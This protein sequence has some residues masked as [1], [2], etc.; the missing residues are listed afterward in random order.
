MFL[1]QEIEGL[2]GKQ[3]PV[4]ANGLWTVPPPPM[5]VRQAFLLVEK[6]ALGESGI[7]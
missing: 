2:T 4:Q 7:T 3:A 6:A 1:K 5:P